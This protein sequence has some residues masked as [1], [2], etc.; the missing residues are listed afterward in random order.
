MGDNTYSEV[1]GPN[2]ADKVKFV[3]PTGQYQNQLNQQQGAFTDAQGKMDPNA[4]YNAFMGQV[5]GLANAV[6]GPTS[7]ISQMLTA[8]AERNSKLGGEAALAAMPGGA[9]SG[10]GR[11]AFG[12][13]YGKAFSDAAIQ[14]QQAQLGLLSPL[15]QGAQQGQYGVMQTGMNNATGLA[16]KMGDMYTPTY[17]KNKTGWDYAMDV[18]GLV[19]DGVTASKGI[20]LPKPNKKNSKLYD[21]G[22]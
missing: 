18:T 8:Q 17:E 5:P 21:D 20:S 2:S 12:D 7:Q 13:A 1:G 15:L 6:M 22:R 11:Y 3:D 4:A 14:T 9:D 10:A 16:S 19:L